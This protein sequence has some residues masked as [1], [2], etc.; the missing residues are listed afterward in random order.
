[1]KINLNNIKYHFFAFLFL[2]PYFELG[3]IRSL[4][5]IRTSNNIIEASIVL[6]LIFSIILLIFLFVNKKNIQKNIFSVL[7][8][9][10]IFF[11]IGLIV[12]NNFSNSLITFV[13]FFVPL[14]FAILYYNCVRNL[15]YNKLIKK[16]VQYFS[17]YL[18][19]NTI[20]NY[21][22]YGFSLFKDTATET[23]LLSPGGGP[24]ALGYTICIVFI[25][26]LSIDKA[27]KKDQLF[28]L[29]LFFV[30]MS[31]F[32]GSRGSMWPTLLVFIIYWIKPDYKSIAMLSILLILFLLNLNTIMTI[33][34]RLF[35]IGE[36]SRI[37]TWVSCLQIFGKE[38]IVNQLFG[39]GI[40]NFF[41]YNTWLRLVGDGVHNTFKY[42]QYTLIVQPHSNWIYMLMEGGLINF[43][44]LITPFIIFIK[45][46][47]RK[48][49][50]MML[51]SIIAII[52]LIGLDSAF[53]VLPSTGA[54]WWVSIFLLYNIL[55]H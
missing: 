12:S 14:V 13:Y 24:V 20:I 9:N 21:L 49:S 54:I 10:F 40:G 7:I 23:R 3:P 8:L 28:F 51:V 36:E 16:C 22:F 34:P 18:I 39:K 19:I 38:N 42:N 27:Y 52:I 15:D 37:S 41:P 6:L 48:K 32:T 50:L 29:S 11:S 30:L 35:N 55:K 2:I 25:L 53:F 4:L 47:L 46:C 44:F 31:F 17:C 26:M 1:M 45:E 5:E 43:I 33:F